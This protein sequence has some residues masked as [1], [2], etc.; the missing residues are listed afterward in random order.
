MRLARWRAGREETASRRRR[1]GMGRATPPSGTGGERLCPAAR[2]HAASSRVPVVRR[3]QR[4][5]GVHAAWGVLEQH[6]AVRVHVRVGV[7]GLA[8][9]RQHARHDLVHGVDQVEELVVR[10]VLERKLALQRGGNA[11]VGARVARVGAG[12]RRTPSHPTPRHATPGHARPR[13]G[14][15]EPH[16]RGVAR[17]R[18]AEHGVAIAR[19]D[20]A[21]FQ[22]VPRKLLDA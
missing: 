5:G 2:V 1:R 7:L 9:L 4:A 16:L 12:R 19:D 8:V 11:R 3:R 20:L 21:R 14:Q 13:H 17:V 22:R 6:A 10:H 18:L 15:G